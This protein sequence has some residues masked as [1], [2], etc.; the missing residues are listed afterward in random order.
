MKGLSSGML[1]KMTSLAQPKPRWA[2]VAVAIAS[3]TW[4][5]RW[6]ASMLIPARREATLT[7]AQ[8]RWVCES[9]SGSE[10]MTTASP[11][12]I[13]LCTSAVKPPTKSTRQSAAAAS[14]V[15]ASCTAA[16][17]P[18]PASSVAAG[19]IAIRLLITGMPYFA[20]TRSQTSTSRLACETIFCR[21]L[22]HRCSTPGAAQSSRFKPSVT[23]RTSRCSAC[24]IW[25]VE[26]ISSVRS[27]F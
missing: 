22:R 19:E 16:A 15:R 3:S 17:W 20:P 12:V 24:N 21:T 26:S 7:D 27:I 18:W 11:A 14:R 25:I 6:M 8:T 10:S 13:P 2:A 23:L 1:A 4:P 9:T 5:R